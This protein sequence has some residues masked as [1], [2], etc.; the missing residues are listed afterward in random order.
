MNRVVSLSTVAFD[1]HARPVAL[2]AAA[3][4]GFGHVE[5]AYIQGYMDF[6]EDDLGD[7]PAVRLRAELAAHGLGCVA[8]SAH[9]DAGG[10][11]AAAMLSRRLRFAAGI[12]ASFVVTNTTTRG[13]REAFLRHVAAVLPLA[14]SLGVALA[15]ENPGFGDDSLIGRAADAAAV[16]DEFRSPW[17]TLNYDAG[18]VFTFNYERVAPQDDLPLALPLARHLHLKDVLA[19]ADGWQFV[20]LGEGSIDTP[21]LLRM[22]A[23]GDVPV[24]LELPLRLERPGCGPMVRQ[25]DPLPV[26]VIESAVARSLAFVRASLGIR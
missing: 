19:S 11:D 26:P 5:P 9:M 16:L 17:V 10:E 18:N 2:E 7:V 25:R 20:A 4:L 1:G 8:V 21:A 22:L 15:F 23:G 13:R 3:R 24:A 14:Q 6:T 12:G